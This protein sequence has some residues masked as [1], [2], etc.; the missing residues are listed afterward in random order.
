MSQSPT[1]FYS[2]SAGSGKTYTLAQDYLTLLFKNSYSNGYRKIL[3]VTFTNKAVGE[4]K[5]RILEYLYKF[6]FEELED[7]VTGIAAHIQQESGLNS[8]EFRKKAQAIFNQLLHDYSAFDIVTIDSFNHRILRTFAKDIDLPDNFEVELD[9]K[10]LISKAIHNLIARAGKDKKLTQL[11]VDFSL[12]KIEE[13]KSWD[14]EYDLQDIAKLIL[15]ENH[16]PY[17]KQLKDKEVEDFLRFRESLYKKINTTQKQLTETAK[18]LVELSQ[19]SNIDPTD[20]KGGS[21]SIFNTVIKVAG[22]DFSVGLETASVR[23]LIAGDLYPKGKSQDIKD[24]IDQM[25]GE[26]QSFAVQYKENM[27]AVLFYKNIASSLTPLSLLNELLHEIDQ[28][29][30]N[31]QIVPI[32]EFNAL[33]AEQIKDEPAPFIYER[34]GERYRHYFIDEFQDTSRMQW[35]NLSPLIENELQQQRENQERGSLMLVG[36]AKQ[37]IY[38]FRGGD[39]D[40]FLKLLATP[41]LFMLPKKEETLAFN[42]R[43]YDHIIDFNN[44]FFDSYGDHLSSDVYKTLYKKYL[45]QETRSKEGGFIQIDFI[46]KDFEAPYEEDDYAS[47]YPYHVHQQVLKA[48]ASGFSLGEI[49]VLVRANKDGHEIAKYLVSQDMRVV[50]GDS[51][52]V[53][54]SHK[55]Q[56]L[57]SLIKMI[58]APE[59][60]QPR[61]EFLMAYTKVFQLE[62]IHSFVTA[63]LHESLQTLGGK[64]M[65]WEEEDLGSAFAKAA[66]FQATEHVAESLGLF[67]EQ[68]TRL[69]SFMEFLFEYST[70]Y[71]VSLSGFI[72]HWE[73]KMD[74]LSVPAAA[75]AD[76]VQ[77]MTIHKSKGLEFPVVIVPHCD[78]KLDEARNPTGWV[79]VNEVE[80]EGFDQ[81]YISLKKENEHY[82]ELAP[83]VYAQHL[84][85]AEMDQINTLYVAFTRA[86]EQLYISAIETNSKTAC[87]ASLLM[88]F[89][90]N[91]G[92][93]LTAEN[94]FKTVEIGDL[95]RKSEV[96]KPEQSEMLEEY[97]VHLDKERLTIS[98]RRG[99]LW[100]SGASEAIQKGN[101]LHEYLSLIQFSTDYEEVS[102]K[103]DRDFSLSKKEQSEMKEM[104]SSV[105]YHP[106]LTAYYK[107]GVKVLNEQPILLPS[108]S[109]LI[110]DRVVI[111]GDYAVVIDYKTGAVLNKHKSQV[112]EYADLLESMDI[113]VAEKVL[114]YTDTLEI[115]KWNG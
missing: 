51:L 37:S 14:I 70:G 86:R 106:D 4:M 78:K 25:A 115:V 104:I 110:P 69:Q 82:P 8:E 26:I 56:L 33:L 62:D 28:I 27:G 111:V 99:L 72:E 77:I 112:N 3:A 60:Q 22:E 96:T 92:I 98:T 109:K 36:D 16:Y 73:L 6:T 9:S 65:G 58:Q 48:Q 75:D 57:V 44:Q 83:E 80:Y 90:Q 59:Q 53:H 15:N 89:V 7:S 11:L 61:L 74:K 21:R 113:K 79:E 95:A 84:A 71:E 34:L 39:A 103:I 47:V 38:R 30:I 93:E 5:E 105:I 42:W 29:K 23:D 19:N 10:R 64:L 102:H 50:S 1:T 31:E 101:V 49:C 20:F 55:V 12:S 94:G 46:E 88:D 35:E 43:S 66:L 41:D 45:K 68:D 2:A 32:Y 87:Y 81:V 85:K 13:G 67:K 54:A 108:G 63:H 100:A 107:D 17:L 91:K 24:R 76:A 114:V 52:L 18:A 40:Q 97:K